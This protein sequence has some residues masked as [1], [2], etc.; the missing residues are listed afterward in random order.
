MKKVNLLP[1]E[2]RLR[3]EGSLLRYS[4]ATRFVLA[5][6]AVVAGLVVWQVSDLWRYEAGIDRLK[7][8]MGQLRQTMSQLKGQQQVLNVK[9]SE[10]TVAKEQWESRRRALVAA[11]QPEVPISTVLA[12]L[13]GVLPEEVW[14]TKLSLTEENLKIMG[15]SPHAQSAADLIARLDDSKKFQATKFVNTQK[16]TQAGEEVFTFE[17]VTEPILTKPPSVKP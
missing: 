12:E 8:E 16:L 15:A 9:R 17:I 14:I 6:V 5:G 4:P 7:K 10:L 13:I 3:K 2:L 11:R 1:K